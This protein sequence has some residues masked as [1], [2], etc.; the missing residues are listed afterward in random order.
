MIDLILG[1]GQGGSR[2][3][4]EF[5]NVYNVPGRYM[6][7]TK[8]DFSKLEVQRNRTLIFEYGGSG[9]DPYVGERVVRHRMKD[10]EAFLD[11][12]IRSTKARRVALCV[13]GGGGSGIGFMFPIIEHLQKRRIKDILLIYTMPLK[14]EGMPTK[15]NA[16][17]ALNKIIE[18]YIGHG[19][20]KDKQV[21]LLLVDNEFCIGKY[22]DRGSSFW[23][24]LNKGVAYALKRFYNLTNLEHFKNYVD[25]AT[26][27]S[28]LDYRE[29]MKI[30]F[31]KEGLLDVR[32]V[33]FKTPD[34]SELG[35]TFKTSSLVFGSLDIRTSKAY[36]VSLAIPELWRSNKRM[37]EFTD[38]VFKIIA[39][40]TKTPYVLRS[41][42]FNSKIVCAKLS[43]LAAGLNKSHGLDKIIGQTLKDVEKFKAKGDLEEF[44]LSGLEY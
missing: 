30:L 13:G 31:F 28:A 21:A 14:A 24:R 11:D 5:S 7:L 35:K 25:M 17:I 27:Y 33:A 12:A 32:E 29:F 1:C 10:V 39:K 36:I 18:R 37:A 3:A 8:V 41:S 6:N 44:D 4:K 38:E 2:L 42:Y 9:R 26:G 15:P 34:T 23:G 19:K 20:A 16:L 40:M 43:I 22:G